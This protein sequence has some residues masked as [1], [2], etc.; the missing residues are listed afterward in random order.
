MA[1]FKVDDNF[2]D[3]PKVD[4]LSL[5]AIGLW[6]VCG[7]YSARHL[8]DGFIPKRRINRLGGDESL[9]RELVEAELW[10]VAE[11]GYQYRNWREY[12]PTRDEV[13]GKKAQARERQK[14]K[15]ERDSQGKFTVTNENVTR[16]KSVSHAPV[17]GDVT[18]GVASLDKNTSSSSESA[19][20]STSNEKMSPVEAARV[21]PH[22]LS[23]NQVESVDQSEILE[24][25]T[26]DNKRDSRESHAVSHTTPV[27]T[28]PDPTINLIMSDFS[29]EKPRPDVDAILDRIDEHCDDHGFKRPART[30]GNLN[31]ARLMLDKDKRSPDEITRILDW[32]TR[33]DFWA[34]NIRSAT[35]LRDKFDQ[36]KGQAQRGR[37]ASSNTGMAPN[38]ERAMNTLQ[39]GARLQ[40]EYD[41][42]QKGMF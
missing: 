19:A 3:H 36:L 4:E 10:L 25:V 22:E 35:K 11:G 1:W 32:V 29:T 2:Y 12:Q 5:E 40:A 30:K 6:T 17:T 27:P 33:S 37:T 42:Q 8:T 7:T 9:A 20:E 39:I 28:R 14:R 15:R 38:S 18:H 13:E 34:P 41:H 24:D 23:E 26:R 16:D 31:A 21:E